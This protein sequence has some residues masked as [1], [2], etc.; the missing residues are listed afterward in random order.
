MPRALITGVQ[1]QTGYYLAEELLRAGWEV[2]GTANIP[3]SIPA[4]ESVE[5]HKADFSAPGSL[6]TLLTT[7]QPKLV[8]NLAAISS[9]AEAWKSPAATLAVNTVAVAEIA[10]FVSESAIKSETRVVQASSA[11]IFGNSSDTV[12][13]EHTPIAPI[14]P[15]GV[16]KAASHLLGQTYRRTGLG[17]SN[18]ILFN[19][20]SPRR[21]LTFLSRKVSNAVAHISLGLQETIELGDL[22]SQRD[23]GWAPDYAQAL[24]LIAQHD[25]ADDFIVASGVAHSVEDYVKTAFAFVGIENWQERV[26]TNAEFMRP[27][28]VKVSVG[29]SSKISQETGWKP[30]VSFHEMVGRMVQAD[31]ELITQEMA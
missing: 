10:E 2:H 22:S 20:E 13:T 8:V 18:A 15:Y 29:D 23:W 7:I 21:P 4:Q 16:S 9:V 28:E 24:A 5:L 6:T 11:E 27:T 26:S 1:G 25:A 19:H 31:L 17:W 14:N 12:F 30:T 3:N